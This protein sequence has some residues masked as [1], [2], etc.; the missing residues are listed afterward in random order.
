[1]ALSETSPGPFYRLVVSGPDRGPVWTGD[2]GCGHAL[3]TG[4]DFRDWYTQRLT[5]NH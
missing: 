5:T 4:P 3:S 1:M 2:L